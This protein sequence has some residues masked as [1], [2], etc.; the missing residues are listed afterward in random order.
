MSQ[1]LQP[2]RVK[3][4]LAGESGQESDPVR[5]RGWIRTRR[6]SKAGLSFLN[7][8]DGSCFDPIQVVAQNTLEN[9][10]SE[11]LRLTTSCAVDVEGTIAISQGK[12]QSIEIH[13]T[14]VT[15]VGMVEDPD[16]YPVPAK[17]HTFGNKQHREGSTTSKWL[18]AM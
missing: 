13:A 5:V 9:Y 10:E 16:T 4:V 15:V 6:D 14:K 7:V 12:G 11:I 8:H 1:P 2:S 17:R 3:D 18:P